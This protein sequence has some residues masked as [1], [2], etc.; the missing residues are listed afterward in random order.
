MTEPQQTEELVEELDVVEVLD[1]TER[2][3]AALELALAG[4][5]L[6]RETFFI[7]TDMTGEARGDLC[8]L[9][10]SLRDQ[11]AGKR[12]RGELRAART[13]LNNEVSS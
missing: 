10:R 1:K 8:E 11:D 3:L 6:P 7:V 12:A 9:A 2:R 5:K 4:A 13:H